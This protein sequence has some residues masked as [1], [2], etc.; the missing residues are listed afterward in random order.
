MAIEVWS[1]RTFTSRMQIFGNKVLGR[2]SSA[3][4]YVGKLDGMDVACKVYTFDR[5]SDKNKHVRTVEYARDACVDEAKVHAFLKNKDSK[6]YYRFVQP[7]VKSFCV[8]EQDLYV[9][10]FVCGVQSLRHF[11]YKTHTDRISQADTIIIMSHV[12]EAVAWLHQCNVVHCDLSSGNII[13]TVDEEWRLIDFG[14]SKILCKDMCVDA[15]HCTKL[16][17]KNNDQYTCCR[18]YRAPEII[19]RT[20][21][22]DKHM[23]VWS[24]GCMLGELLFGKPIFGGN[25]AI[26]TLYQIVSY[27]G[28]PPASLLRLS[29]SV[30]GF[31]DDRL[32]PD[33]WL[34]EEHFTIDQYDQVFVNAR[35]NTVNVGIE[36]EAI[37]SPRL[38]EL[39]QFMLCYIDKRKTAAECV[40]YIREAFYTQ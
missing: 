9:N 12:L 11:V 14:A 16:T 40:A 39:L 24:V 6:N 1:P 20:H 10:V 25:D 35:F 27:I 32:R 30:H 36:H 13:Q 15:C 22:P 5:D 3:N 26:E 34:C 23:D 7:L 31:Q 21:A 38:K 2:G 4:V 18:W 37:L 28:V 33:T 29:I 17:C 19:L 8:L